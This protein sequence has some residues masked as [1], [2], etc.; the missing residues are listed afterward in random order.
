MKARRNTLHHILAKIPIIRLVRFGGVGLSGLVVNVGLLWLLTT[1]VFGERF[2]MLSAVIS[3]E[4][5]II[6]NFYWNDLWT[7]G[8]RRVSDGWVVRL[9]KFHGS[10][11]LGMITNL[12]VLYLLTDLAGLYYLLSNVIAIG[13]GTLVNYLTSDKWVWAER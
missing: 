13:A 1:Y 3:I 12:A 9:F 11:F 8:D 5:S 7:F 4:A 2:Y 6:N 10:R